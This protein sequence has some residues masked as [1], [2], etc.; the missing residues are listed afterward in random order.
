VGRVGLLAAVPVIAAMLAPPVHALDPFQ[1]SPPQWRP[2][3]GPAPELGSCQS[4]ALVFYSLRYGPV[5]FCRRHFRYR[6]GALDCY[7][8]ID[9]V[10]PT[11]DPTNGAVTTRSRAVQVFPCPA[12]IEP[13]VCRTPDLGQLP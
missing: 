2:L 8:F 4:E 13:P 12:G 6:P 7:Q 1:P 3:P 5:G 9:R 10:C 11:L